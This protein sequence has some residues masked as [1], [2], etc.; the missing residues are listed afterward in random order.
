VI[1]F[2][3]LVLYRLFISP[4]GFTYDLTSADVFLLFLCGLIRSLG[5]IF[6]IRAF[7]LDKAGRTAG[8]NFLQIITGYSADMIFFGY[9]MRSY[10][11]VGAS[12]IVGCSVMV[13]VLKARGYSD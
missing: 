8:L 2:F 11:I 1:S 5:M 3:A 13:F 9:S 4:N 7:Q 10:E 12:V 6:F